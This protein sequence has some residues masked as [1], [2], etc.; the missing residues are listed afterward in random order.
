MYG[1]WTHCFYSCDVD[2]YESHIK[3]GKKLPMTQFDK[4]YNPTSPLYPPATIQHLPSNYSDTNLIDNN[5]MNGTHHHQHTKFTIDNGVDID[6]TS[7]GSVAP[8]TTSDDR[9]NMSELER[10]EINDRMASGTSSYR[11]PR[12][13]SATNAFKHAQSVPSNLSSL[14]KDLNELWIIFPRPPYSADVIIHTMLD[15]ILRSLINV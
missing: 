11:P 2:S 3:S 12:K 7:T 4:N 8:D 1:Y 15:H 6:S 10:L 5:G 13:A 9:D 14:L